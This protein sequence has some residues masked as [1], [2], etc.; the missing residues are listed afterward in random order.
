MS[1]NN[2]YLSPNRD[3]YLC[4]YDNITHKCIDVIESTGDIR[5]TKEQKEK[6]LNE[7]DP[8]YGG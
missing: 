8:K 5:L 7:V 3:G 1:I 4:A 6:Y 2:F